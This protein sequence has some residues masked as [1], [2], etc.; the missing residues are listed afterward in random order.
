VLHLECVREQC[1]G[2]RLHMAGMEWP[3]QRIAP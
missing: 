1:S 2:I 3:G